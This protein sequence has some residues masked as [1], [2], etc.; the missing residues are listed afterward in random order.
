MRS[1]LR[2]FVGGV[3]VAGLL[4]V[5]VLAV[6]NGGALLARADLLLAFFVVAIVVAELFPLDIPGHEGQATFSTTFAFALLL[7]H[8]IAAVVVVHSVAV[9]VA[10][11]I[12]RRSPGKALFNGAQYAL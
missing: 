4:L 3:T 10:D 8:G 7:A 9:I 1:L 12:Q 2:P 6:R 5:A 11:V